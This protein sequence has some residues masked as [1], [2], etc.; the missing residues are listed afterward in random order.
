MTLYVVIDEFDKCL[1]MGFI[2]MNA[3]ISCQTWNAGYCFLQTD[4]ESIPDSS[5]W[6]N[7]SH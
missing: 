2:E 5:I 6:Q 4:A 1:E 3:V 7:D